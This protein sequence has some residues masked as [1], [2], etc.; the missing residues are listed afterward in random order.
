M[1][2]F[3]CDLCE[4]EFDTVHQ[5]S[6]H[7]MGAHKS[8]VENRK[9]R[10]PVGIRRTKLGANIASDKVGRWVNDEPGR[11]Q[12]FIDGGYDFVEDPQ[13]IDSSDDIGTRKCKVVDRRTGKK[14][15]LMQIDKNLYNQDQAVKQARNDD[16]D[17]RIQ[18]GKLDNKLGNAGYDAGIKY[19]PKS[20]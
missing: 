1:G 19:E 6:G 4:K 17:K 5:L 7:K 10:I 12:A 14:A 2:E 15:Y 13:A 20:T 16:I 18:S 8:R 11:L 9:E 3:N